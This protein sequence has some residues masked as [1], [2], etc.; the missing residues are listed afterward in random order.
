MTMMP[1]LTTLAALVA[2]NVAHADG[3]NDWGRG[4]GHMTWG[5]GYG[6]FGGLMMLAFWGVVIV[7]IVMAVRWFAGDRP[8]VDA[9]SDAMDI[10]KSRFAKGELD[11]DE[12]RK[13]K[14]ALED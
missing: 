11:E 9:A 7:L 13:R 8:G 14:A 5:G 3:A 6:M 4:F 12:F 2:A 1:S 10:L